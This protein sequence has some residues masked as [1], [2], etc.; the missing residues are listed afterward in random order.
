ME[1]PNFRI[2]RIIR[3]KFIPGE[4]P[5][6]VRFCSRCPTEVRRAQAP[7]IGMRANERSGSRNPEW[8]GAR[9]RERAAF[10]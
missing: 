1:Q 8:A 2:K 10:V 7:G 5:T 3:S 6:Q 4:R 9:R